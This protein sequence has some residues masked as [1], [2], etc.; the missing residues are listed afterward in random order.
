MPAIESL[1]TAL[2]SLARNPVLFLP[3]LLY[4]LILLPQTATQLLGI[5]LVPFL[6]QV[7]TFFVTPFVVAG[8]LGMAA[9]SLGGETD[10]STFASVGKARYV[11]LLLGNFIQLG[12]AIAFG[13]L[14][15]VVALVTIFVVGVGGG[16]AGGFT[17]ASAGS[18]AIAA[19]LVVVVVLLWI[20][21]AFFI[22]FFG[23]A[24]VV[25]GA[26]AIDGFRRSVSLVRSN[27]VSAL[28]YSV[29]NFLVGVLTSLPVTAFVGYRAFQR[30]QAGAPA[31][32]TPPTGGFGAM[33]LLSPVEVAAVSLL[34]LALAMVL[35]AFRQTYAT[36]F[37][38]RHDQSVEERVLAGDD[39]V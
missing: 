16:L 10:L 5:P 26:D 8:I 20:V 19:A 15:V 28:G 37:Y 21:V 11:P 14:F 3:G 1:R 32:G 27:L 33:T 2:R 22:Q 18:L 17:G 38:T 29:I 24:I 12:I 4:G 23:V 25:D 36:A 9:E 35:T 30:A 13:V 31:G 34:S 7:V 39:V 6:L